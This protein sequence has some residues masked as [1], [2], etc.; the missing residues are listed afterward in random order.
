MQALSARADG[1]G[2]AGPRPGASLR[3]PARVRTQL[4]QGLGFRV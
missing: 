4:A 1:E 3:V 2:P